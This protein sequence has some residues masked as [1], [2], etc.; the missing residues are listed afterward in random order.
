MAPKWLPERSISSTG[1]TLSKNSAQSK[2]AITRML[3][4]TL[5]T[6]TFMAAWLWW[7]TRT[8]SSGDVPS[9]ESCSSSHESAGVDS[10][11]CSRRR[12]TSFTV[13]AMG[14]AAASNPWKARGR[15]GRPPSPSS[16]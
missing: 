2:V 13:K 11:S 16:S 12:W 10:G 4:I 6:V 1:L 7:S 5:R 15:A 8:S 3:V 14:K 9:F